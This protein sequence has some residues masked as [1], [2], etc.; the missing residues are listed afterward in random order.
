MGSLVGSY[1]SSVRQTFDGP[2]SLL[3]SCQCWPVGRERRWWWLHPLCVTQQFH[4]ASIA[5]WLSFT[6]MSHHNLLPHIPLIHLS[7]VNSS[8]WPGIAP[9]SLNSS[10][11]LLCLPGEGVQ[12]MYVFL[13]RVCMPVGRAVWLSFHLGCHRSA[14]SLSAL[15]ISP[16]TQTVARM[17]GSDP[18]FSCPTHQGQVQNTPVFP[19]SSLFVPSFAWLYIFFSSGQVLLSALSWCSACTSVSEG[20]F[21]M[22]PWREMYSV[23]TYSSNVLFSECWVLFFIFSKDIS[24]YLCQ[25]HQFVSSVSYSFQY[26]R[27]HLLKFIC[28][29]FIVLDIV[30]FL[31]SLSDCWSWLIDYLGRFLNL[32]SYTFFFLICRQYAFPVVKNLYDFDSLNSVETF[33]TSCTWSIFVN[34]LCKLGNFIFFSFFFFVA[35]F[36]LFFLILFYF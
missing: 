31:I 22:Y 12:G 30:S 25:F 21:L 18:C 16:L 23:S 3:F 9:Q 5:T 20:V 28:K 29:Y 33:F 26:T 11:Q 1:S 2:A 34:V 6:G 32:K 35:C 14:V 10:S 7:T 36:Y 27:I 15:K 19:P 13:Y 4:L 17:W 24:I 8:P